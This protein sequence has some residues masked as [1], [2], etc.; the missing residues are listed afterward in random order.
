ML[1]GIVS[2][3]AQEKENIEIIFAQNIHNAA[4]NGAV[5]KTDSD[6]RIKPYKKDG[7]L[8]IPLRFTAE[9]AGYEIIWN[10]EEFCAAVNGKN[11]VPYSEDS[12]YRAELLQGRIFMPIEDAARLLDLKTE[13]YAV[14]AAALYR[15]EKPAEDAAND[16]YKRIN[17][18][19]LLFSAGKDLAQSVQAAQQLVEEY[20]LSQ[21]LDCVPT[22]SG[23]SRV[24]SP[25]S[26]DI[27]S[28]TWEW[29][30][31]TPNIIKDTNSGVV[32]PVDNE[33]YPLKHISVTVMSGKTV[34]VPYYE[35][36][37]GKKSLIDAI[38][39]FKKIEFMRSSILSL[40]EAY[41]ATGNEEYSY[42]I[43]AALYKWAKYVPDYYM[44]GNDPSV[45]KG[46]NTN[47]PI[48]VEEARKNDFAVERASSENGPFTEFREH[49]IYAYDRIRTSD[50]LKKLS[51]EEGIDAGKFIETNLFE[52]ICDFL[53][54]CQTPAFH[55][56]SNLPRPMTHLGQ[57]AQMLHK[58]EYIAFIA[59]YLAEACKNNGR[60]KMYP[61][62]F[63][64]H[65][66]YIGG[67][68]GVG[69]RITEYY[70]RYEDEAG[71]I[72][73]RGQEIVNYLTEC[74][75]EIPKVY[76]PT[77]QYLPTGD[78]NYEFKDAY[79]R[80]K[81][82]SVLLPAYGHLMFGGGEN[83]NQT[84]M[85]LNFT[86]KANH[87]HSDMLNLTLFAK[88]KEL[89]GDLGY[90]HIGG[91]YYTT[92]AMAHN[93]VVIDGVTS[94]DKNNFQDSGNIGHLFMG[95]NLT[96]YKPDMDGISVSEVDGKR[97]YC[98]QNTDV[99]RYQR[100]NIFN[101]TD[102]NHPYIIDL[103]RVTGGKK[104]EYFMHGSADPSFKQTAYSTLSLKEVNL[105]YPLLDNQDEWKEPV[106]MADNTN[107]YGCFRNM[108]NGYSQEEWQAEFKNDQ[109]DANVKFYMLDDE[110]SEVWLGESP[111]PNDKKGL[112]A[113]MRPAMMIRKTDEN[114][115]DSLF[116]GVIEVTGKE[117]Y[118]TDVRRLKVKGDSKEQAALQIKTKDQ[119]TETYLVNLETEEI[120]GTA[121]K[122][123][124]TEDGRFTLSGRAA[125]ITE[126]NGKC[127]VKLIG[128][129]GVTIDGKAVNSDTPAFYTGEVVSGSFENN[130]VT[131]RGSLPTG[132]T[133]SG[134]RISICYPRVDTVPKKTGEY[135]YGIKYQEDF[136]QQYEI[137]YVEEGDGVF[138]IHLAED[139][140]TEITENGAEEKVRP[141]RSFYGK[142]TFKIYN[143]QE[144]DI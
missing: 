131:V 69:A 103:F 8:Y 78:T 20:T 84:Q 31:K 44:T 47:N 9:N 142:T 64:Y 88:G 138:V 141:Y 4:V 77:G 85:N 6:V 129:Q 45:G 122:L 14:G 15:G 54:K 12:S 130:T 48:G 114:K 23:R 27:H 90:C 143:T 71:E 63:S 95:G 38:I 109:G 25:A 127:S 65:E 115:A 97:A 134:N 123:L 16:T 10:D 94:Y 43:A 22:Q 39:N 5:L 30:P 125:V 41:L 96:L 33:K 7:V 128:A 82:T 11:I 42:R 37:D 72:R 29:S 136:S 106:N 126:Q 86:D 133:L 46:W 60:D 104:H 93:T 28:I 110:K 36:P 119:K 111:V 91:R 26:P 81:T 2:V 18:E 116:A 34:D 49:E 105:K 132:S 121:P 40:S 57:V 58:P 50:G 19:P 87:T 117:G 124:E 21:W 55:A 3:Q 52:N 140:G 135:L 102:I 53:T 68:I 112:Y 108:K 61:E 70:R 80:S 98:Y 1:F 56:S 79:K 144:N 13:A 73:E 113:A 75:N 59:D 107:W 17:R 51:A 67:L 137:S 35:M 120:T 100:F 66:G 62:T 76:Y 32:F 139:L 74:R 99:T 83:E 101:T 92:S 89:L 24:L 118:I